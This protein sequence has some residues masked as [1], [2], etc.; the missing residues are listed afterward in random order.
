MATD[1]PRHRPPRGAIVGPASSPTALPGPFPGPLLHLQLTGQEGGRVGTAGGTGRDV[2][3]EPAQFGEVGGQ[4]LITR[5][6]YW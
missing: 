3:R 5:G 2:L 4:D 1:R 6:P